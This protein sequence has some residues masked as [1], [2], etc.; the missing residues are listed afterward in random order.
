MS[1]RQDARD[2]FFHLV[3]RARYNLKNDRSGPIL[4]LVTKQFTHYDCPPSVVT[5]MAF[6]LLVGI[7][8][9][10]CLR[11]WSPTLVTRTTTRPTLVSAPPGV[12][13][14]TTPLLSAKT[15]SL[16]G[17]GLEAAI[18]R[19]LTGYFLQTAT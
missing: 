19:P 11:T 2:Q 7:T 15:S 12:A 8:D 10:S 14:T 3:A 1:K 9:L 18:S 16:I 6:Q 5:A 4:A 17:T 13:V